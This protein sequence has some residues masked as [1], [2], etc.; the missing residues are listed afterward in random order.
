MSLD[1]ARRGC[2]GLDVA[3]RG[4]DGLDVAWVRVRWP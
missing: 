3:R 1:V 2:D 4:C